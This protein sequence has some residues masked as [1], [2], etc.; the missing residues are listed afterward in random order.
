MP[1]ITQ[2]P[3][4]YGAAALILAVSAS[5]CHLSD[6]EGLDDPAAAGSTRLTS[7]SLYSMNLITYSY[8]DLGRLSR[9]AYRMGDIEIDF[10]YSPATITIPE[11]QGSEFSDRDI[12]SDITFNA[13]GTVARWKDEE[14]RYDHT[15]NS[16]VLDDTY[17][18]SCDYDSD[19]HL[20]RFDNGDDPM[21]LTWEN[22]DLKKI[23]SED[24]GTDPDTDITV[25]YTNLE[26]K[27]GQWSAFWMPLAIYGTTGLF[28]KAPRHLPARFSG[29]EQGSPADAEFAYQINNFGMI[30]LEKMVYEDVTSVYQYNYAQ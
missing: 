19:G 7:I 9:I 1:K 27:T 25:L 21:L 11:Y 18:Q 6:P 12:W 22:G 14:Y 26:N 3:I 24:H 5:S 4:L 15:A 17:Y 13:D 16:W 10:G 23:V 28:G 2:S 20:V 8:D 30:A 29:T